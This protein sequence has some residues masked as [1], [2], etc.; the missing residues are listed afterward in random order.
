MNDSF[1][2][3]NPSKDPIDVYFRGQ[4]GEELVVEYDDALYTLSWTPQ[5]SQYRGEID[6]MKGYMV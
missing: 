2:P 6:G 3:L 5:Y 4:D 1:Y